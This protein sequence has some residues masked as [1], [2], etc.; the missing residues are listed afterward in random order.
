MSSEKSGE[1][2]NYSSD[3][4]IFIEMAMTPSDYSVGVIFFKYWG[5]NNDVFTL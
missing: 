4:I 3:T 2:K 5:N 1:H